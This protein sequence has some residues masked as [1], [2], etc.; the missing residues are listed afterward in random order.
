MNK[1]I[2]QLINYALKKQLIYEEDIDYCIN[3]LLDLFHLDEFTKIETEDAPLEEILEAM[4]EYAVAH[5]LCKD[6]ITSKDLFDTRIMD[7]VM[8]R[9]HEVI[10]D[11]NNRYAHSPHD[12][13][14][15]FYNLSISSN[16]IRMNRVNKNIKFKRDTKYGPLEITINLSKPEKD[17]KEI[18]KARLLKSSGYPQCLLCKENVGFAGDLRR[19]ARENHRIIPLNLSNDRYYLQYSPYV[20]YN[21]HCIVFNEE[22]IPMKIDHQ[23]FTHLLDFIEQFPHYMLGSNADLPIVGGSILTHDHYQ[24]GAYHFP[25]EDAKVITNYQIEGCHVELLH[26]PLSTIRLTSPSKDR[27]VQLA[28]HILE[29]WIDYDDTSRHIISHTED[30]RHNTITPI[31]RRA[32]NDYQMD[33]V[34]RNNR[35]TADYPLGIFHPHQE[36]HHIKKEN[37]GLIEVMGLAILPARLKEEM[38]LLKDCLLKK[39]TIDDYECLLKHKEWFNELSKK[40]ITEDNV[41]EIIKQGLADVFTSVLEDAGVYK[42]DEDGIKGFKKFV[43][44]TL[45]GEIL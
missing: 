1:E 45:K 38:S 12:A 18:A 21:E 6:N 3:Q 42:M 41:D 20:Y 15:Y 34:L 10:Q 25:I 2:C 28:D 29:D 16:Y 22:H 32:G 7:K 17:P 30:T 19:P 33:L 11:F 37:I 26:W 43:N 40:D 27:L 23:T 35:T 13:T 24:G 14:D 4:L 36:N 31:A 8:P 44:Y 39:K 9:P 5:D